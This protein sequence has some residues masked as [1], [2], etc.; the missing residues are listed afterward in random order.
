MRV[1]PVN[2]ILNATS[3]IYDHL[4]LTPNNGWHGQTAPK[5]S[6]AESISVKWRQMAR[7]SSSC[8]PCETVQ[9]LF[10][11]FTIELKLTIIVIVPSYK[12]VTD[13]KFDRKTLN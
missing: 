7:Y 12:E 4:A 13:N 3:T 10:R 8:G 11:W 1:I 2:G 6:R 5:V 9:I